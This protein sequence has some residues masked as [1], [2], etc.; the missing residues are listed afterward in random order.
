MSLFAVSLNRPEIKFTELLIPWI[1]V[2]A[3]LGFLAAWFVVA[4]LER[5]GWSRYI[6]HL[7]LFFLALVVLFSSVIGMVFLP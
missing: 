7:P 2:I 3:L 5:T 6:W 4:I 1:V